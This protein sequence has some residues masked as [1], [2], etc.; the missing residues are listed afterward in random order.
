MKKPVLIAVLAVLILAAGA[1]ALMRNGND[2]PATNTST[3]TPP[4]TTTEPPVP[5]RPSPSSSTD[6]ESST[7]VYGNDGFSP[8][9]L[10]VKAGT[11]ITVKNE[12]SRTLEFD[13]D[14]HPVHTDNK[15]LNLD[16]IEAGETKTLTVHNIGRW[17]FHNH[18]HPGDTG[19]LTV[20]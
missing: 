5:A 15:E 16:E 11:T 9:T 3:T 4:T 8:A 14:P 1:F 20:E 12:S 19:S 6:N 2:S 18:L 7:I 17:G 10:T 13:S